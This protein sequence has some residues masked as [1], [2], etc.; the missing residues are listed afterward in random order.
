MP[1]NLTRAALAATAAL[2]LAGLAGAPAL[3]DE[4]AAEPTT[5]PSCGSPL[6]LLSPGAQVEGSSCSVVSTVDQELQSLGPGGLLPS[7][8][9][10]YSMPGTGWG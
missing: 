4:A 6:V 8:P 2:T 10:M 5:E 3:A 1:V 9:D 7:V